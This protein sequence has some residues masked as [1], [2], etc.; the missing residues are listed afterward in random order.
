MFFKANVCMTETFLLES[1]WYRPTRKE[2][3]E[4]LADYAFQLHLH[5]CTCSCACVECAHMI[6][7]RH[8]V[9]LSLVTRQNV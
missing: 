9:C 4:L 8:V 6:L 5:E 3:V 2:T 7:W 1:F